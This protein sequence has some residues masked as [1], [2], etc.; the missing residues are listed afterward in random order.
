MKECFLITSYC[1][2]SEK[3][4]VLKSTINSLKEY[5]KDICI[6]SHHPLPINIQNNI[7]YYIY[8]KSNP[9]LPIEQR[10]VIIWRNVYNYRLNILKRDYGYSVSNQFKQGLLFLH[11]VG[12]DIIHIVNYD[13]II[14]NDIIENSNKIKDYSGVFYLNREDEISLLFCSIKVK[15]YLNK[16]KEISQDDYIN[17]NDF[18]Y[19]ES[20]LTDKFKLGN[21]LY[22][23]RKLKDKLRHQ[24]DEFYQYDIKECS[25]HVGERINWIDSDKVYTNKISV[26]FY[27]VKESFDFK[28]FIGYDLYLHETVNSTIIFDTDIMIKDIEQSFGYYKDNQFIEGNKNIKFLINDK[29]LDD[30]ITSNFCLSAIEKNVP[31]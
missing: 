21:N 1:D 25:L 4:D 27:N 24:L 12:Y 22:I 2:T 29:I 13:T 9:I 23:N 31:K 15:D 30:Y 26:F 11:D 14:E 3:K 20:Y 5:N 6:H 7:K 17:M 28:I 10:S 8:D 16:I 18:W 19:A